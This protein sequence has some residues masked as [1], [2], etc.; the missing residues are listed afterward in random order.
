MSPVCGRVS[1]RSMLCRIKKYQLLTL[2]VSFN[3][4]VGVLDYT[5]LVLLDIKNYDPIV[6]MLLLL[7]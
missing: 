2:R 6:Y 5:D 7:A 3:D 1:G 4:S